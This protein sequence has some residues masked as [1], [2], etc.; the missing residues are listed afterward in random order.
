MTSLGHFR[1]TLGRWETIAP[2]VKTRIESDDFE[3]C[4]KEIRSVPLLAKNHNYGIMLRAL[5][6]VVARGP[7]PLHALA[8]VAADLTLKI[9]A[10]LT[11]QMRALETLAAG[12]ETQRAQA[13][14]LARRLLEKASGTHAENRLRALTSL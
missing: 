14:D 1:E 12:D 2:K 13:R 10:T 3:A 7:S 4:L 11:E 5:E 6:A 8:A 9:E